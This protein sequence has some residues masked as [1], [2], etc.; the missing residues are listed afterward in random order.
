[1]KKSVLHLQCYQALRKIQAIIQDDTLEDAVCFMR[2]EE[3]VCIMEEIGVSGGSCH[4][5]G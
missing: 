1:M 2:I 4:D 3:I 5:F